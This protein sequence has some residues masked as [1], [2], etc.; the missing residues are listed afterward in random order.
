MPYQQTST[1]N[2]YGFRPWTTRLYTTIDD[3]SFLKQ[4]QNTILREPAAMKPT[5]YK[6]PEM[7]GLGAVLVTGSGRVL[8]GR[9]RSLRGLGA[10]IMSD[11]FAGNF[12]NCEYGQTC[13]LPRARSPI[14]IV[15]PISTG[16]VL[17]G[18]MPVANP[19]VIQ[20][21]PGTVPTI[22]PPS[23]V[24]PPPTLVSSSPDGTVYSLPGSAGVPGTPFPPPSAAE[25]PP[26]PAAAPSTGSISDWLSSST[27]ISGYSNLTVVGVGGVIAFLAFGRKGRR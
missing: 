21:P 22:L 10:I 15:G 16:P 13:A 23:S 27:I 19:P 20:L 5:I 2:P 9:H 18:P 6:P 11:P 7:R 8:R 14:A 12:P 24:P 1:A 25:L 4:P 17:P 26:A 3:F